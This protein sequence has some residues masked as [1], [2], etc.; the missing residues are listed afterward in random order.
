[1]T[2]LHHF[3]AGGCAAYVSNGPYGRR[4]LCVHRDGACKLCGEAPARCR[5]FE[6][7]VMPADET[8]SATA[9]Y[10][11]TVGHTAPRQDHDPGHAP[12]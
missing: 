2:H 11:L 9:E 5:Y 3:I 8:G 4:H 12:A 1:M 10:F 6:E 7:A